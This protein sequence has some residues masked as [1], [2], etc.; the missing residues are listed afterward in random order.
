MFELLRLITAATVI[1]FGVLSLYTGIKFIRLWYLFREESLFHL[2]MLSL[3]M[4]V[5]FITIDIFITWNDI[6]FVKSIMIKVIPIVLSILCLELS[7]F[8]LTL[9]VNRKTLWE[10]YIPFF[11]GISFGTSLAL[12]GLTPESDQ[13]FWS[14]LIIS[15]GISLS[16]IT[17]LTIKIIRNTIILINSEEIQKKAD[18]RF[19]STLI[20]TSIMLFGGAIADIMLF[21]IMT[22][23]GFDFWRDIV[24]IG[25]FITPPFLIL[26]IW[27]VNRLFRNLEEADIVQIMNLLS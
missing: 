22:I 19:L 4:V 20:Y 11:F 21:S 13:W 16:L 3:G 17:L 14:L 26:T 6:I 8:Y 7:L 27:F 2:G 12:I 23:I 10:K 24:I 1:A 18:R 5:Y 15:Y 25:G 9:F